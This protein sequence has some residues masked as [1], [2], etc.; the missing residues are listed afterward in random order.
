MGSDIV[1]GGLAQLNPKESVYLRLVTANGR[2]LTETVALISEV[3]TWQASLHVP[4]NVSGP[5]QL[6]ASIRNQKGEIL[7]MDHVGVILALDTALGGRYLAL[8]RPVNGENA[9]AGYYLFFDGFAQQAG[10]GVTISLWTENCQTRVAQQFFSLRTS[11]YWRGFL[12]VPRNI[13]GPACAVA[14]FGSPEEPDAWREAQLPINILP[15]DDADAPG[16]RAV[17]IGF[18]SA[19]ATLSAAEPLQ[20]YGT[21]YNAPDDEV[22]V[23]ILLDNGRILTEG[24]A[25]VDDFG[26]WE[27]T[28]ILLPDTEGVAQITASFGNPTDPD[29]AQAQTAITITPVEE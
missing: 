20:L 18:P 9:V 7:A 19:G 11:A 14:Y 29:Y 25:P 1:A 15:A 13:V 17:M 12:V 8:F 4:L 3:N 24:I 27:L 26:Y 5:A 28:L 22:L 6:Q 21:A 2:I 23:S 16:A 10:G